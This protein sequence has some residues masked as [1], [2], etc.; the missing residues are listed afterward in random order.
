[1]STKDNLTKNYIFEAFYQLLIKHSYEDI[2]VSDICDKA[3]VSRMSFYR[4]FKSKEDLLSKSIEK[5]LQNL[6]TNLLAQ[7][8]LSQFV[9]TKEIFASTAQLKEALGAF[10]NTDYLNRFINHISEQLFTFA[11]EDKI[12]PTKKY[13]PVFY[14][15]ALTGVLGFWLNNGAKESPEDMA[16]LICSI[17]DFPI[18]TENNL[19]ID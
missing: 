9:V 16:K 19:H 4:N 11:P 15:N 12:N 13:I 5:T 17:A 3:G 7:N 6:K 14:F 1:M 2:N 18:F 10:K 8:N